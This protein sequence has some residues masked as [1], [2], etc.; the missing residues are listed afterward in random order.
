MPDAAEERL[1]RWLA[2]EC[3]VVEPPRRIARMDAREVLV[4]KFAPG[5]AARAGAALERLALHESP[6]PVAPAYAR[7]ARRRPDAPRVELWREAACEV[8]RG[9]AAERGM[10]AGDAEL[11]VAGVDSVAAVLR[12]VLWRDPVAGEPYAPSPAERRAYVEAA[13]RADGSATGL[14]TRRYGAFEG[15]AVVAH[16]PGATHARALLAAAWRVCAGEPPPARP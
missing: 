6:D 2:A 13:A 11:V 3:G 10:A 14:F 12:A 7:H 8:V 9:R 4:S 16:C 1:R 5:F 15:R